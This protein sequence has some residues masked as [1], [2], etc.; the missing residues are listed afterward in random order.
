M[1]FSREFIR[2]AVCGKPCRPFVSLVIPPTRAVAILRVGPSCFSARH[3]LP[4][5]RFRPFPFFVSCIFLLRAWI[6][7]TSAVTIRAFLESQVFNIS[8]GCPT[9]HVLQSCPYNYR[10]SFSVVKLEF[11]ARVASVIFFWCFEAWP[12]SNSGIGMHTSTINRDAFLKAVYF[13]PRYLDTNED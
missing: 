4:A 8:Q 9:G 12:Q 6:D 5:D 10:S 7:C 1:T 2:P 11:L 13:Y 3:F